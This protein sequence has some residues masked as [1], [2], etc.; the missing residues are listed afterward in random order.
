MY[1]QLVLARMPDPALRSSSHVVQCPGKD[2]CSRTCAVTCAE[3]HLSSLRAFSVTGE[4]WNDHFTPGSPP[5]SSP[6]PPP[7]LPPATPFSE[8]ANTCVLDPKHE[9][10]CR[11]GG[12]GSFLPSLCAFST[13]C[14]ICGPRFDVDQ[15]TQDDSCATSGNGVCEDGGDGSL[16]FAD[17][18]GEQ[19]HLCGFGTDYTDCA[20]FGA[21]LVQTKSAETYAGA[22]NVTRPAPP[23]PEPSPPSP[24][25]PPPI[26]ELFDPCVTD[27][28]LVCHAFFDT[29]DNLLC[30]GTI[31]QINAKFAA[32]VCTSDYG[33][34]AADTT[35][36][37]ECSDG[38]YYSKVIKRK[39]TPFEA[40]TFACD[41]GSQVTRF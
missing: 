9:L 36:T 40:S 32:G 31:T 6:S 27:T 25:S 13:W 10:K 30:S 14:K 28:A 41:Y 18:D 38:G 16:F 24:P 20:S 29:D 15:V 26:V 35:I 12:Y 4:Q 21:R 22:T 8:C 17:V 23:P 39:D 1:K 5:T 11:D 3:Q 7:P 34:Y 19:T 2:D 37:D 33:A